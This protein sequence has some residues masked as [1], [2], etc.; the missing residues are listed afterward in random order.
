MNCLPAGFAKPL[1]PAAQSEYVRGGATLGGPDEMSTVGF[2][3]LGTMGRPMARHLLAAG[4]SLV[5]YARRPEAAVELVAAGARRAAS[6]AEVTRAAEFVV[7]IV[8]ADAEV[9]EVTLG[10]AGV[11]EG[12][13]AGKLLIEMSTI[14]PDTVRQVA[15]RLNEA[16]MAMLDAPVS[17]GPWGAEAATLAIMAGG[18]PDDFD[19]ARPVLEALGDKLFHVGPL[20][21][22]QTIKLVNQMMAG[23][24]M[25]LIGEGFAL[26]QAAGADLETMAEVVAVSSGNSSMFEARARKFVLADQYQAGFT[27]ELMRKDVGLAL[28]MARALKVP[29]PV[30]AA[31]FQQYTAAMNHGFG[32][33]D[34]AAVAK[35]C[36]QSAGLDT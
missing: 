26:A 17:G 34:F 1:Q 4:H 16:G 15:A 23:G 28:E 24:I 14:G 7:T 19:R 33:E 29:M 30:A 32:A 31:A 5:V 9:R 11:V 25:T 27:T 8:T 20:G 18:S 6:P 10:P 36:R 2:I 21:A 35:V 3:G 13:A 12:A 22:G